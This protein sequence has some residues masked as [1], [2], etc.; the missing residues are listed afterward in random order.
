MLLKIPNYS[1][2]FH[3]IEHVPLQ[4][5]VHKDVYMYIMGDVNMSIMENVNMCIMKKT[6]ETNAYKAY[7]SLCFLRGIVNT[8]ASVHELT[9]LTF[10]EFL[11][12]L[13]SSAHVC[14]FS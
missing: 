2:L 4:N 6:S 12:F 9:C 7:T 11:K 13:F 10:N 14:A 3:M 1:W 8:F 5:F